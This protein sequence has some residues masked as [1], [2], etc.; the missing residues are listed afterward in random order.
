MQAIVVHKENGQPQLQWEQVPDLSPGPKEVL[1]DV[2]AAAV[3]R[4]DLSQAQGNYPPPPGV[5]DILGLDMAGIIAEVGERVSG[6]NPGDR[7]FALLPGGGYAEQV[8][9]H[10]GMLLRLPEQWSFVQGAAVPEVW[11]TG[12]VN[13]FLE[14]RLR[15]GETVLI[16]AGGSG[17]GTASIQLARAAGA[18]VIVT[19]GS[20]E[21]LATA[22]RLGAFR[23]I[24]YKREDFHEEVMKATEGK[25]VDL[26]LDPV[27]AS[28]LQP[29]L[30]SLKLLGRLVSIGTLSG[31]RTDI[32]L[33]LILGKRLRLIG[34][35]LRQRPVEEKIRITREFLARFWHHFESGSFKPI[36]DRTF[37]MIDAQRAHDYVR[38]N[39]NIGKV[40]LVN[41]N[42]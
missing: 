32:D 17:V 36:I 18:A 4:A 3:N 38:A 5:T 6:W 11:Y 31:S 10:P 35:T 29:N 25:G 21:K 1:V 14:G 2:H 40:V 27:G 22:R 16:H 24:N 12:F 7:V 42:G 19:A 15:E 23:A 13:L 26:I 8:V 39:R 20:E 41:E 28:H 9:V 33:G 34:S 30:K 37:P